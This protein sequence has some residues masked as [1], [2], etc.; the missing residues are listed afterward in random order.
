MVF[1]KIQANSLYDLTQKISSYVSQ[2]NPKLFKTDIDYLKKDKF[3]NWYTT[4]T[5]DGKL[6]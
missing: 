4:V 1:E 3:N 2:W 5:R 6:K